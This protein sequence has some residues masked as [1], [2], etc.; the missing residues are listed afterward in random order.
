VNSDSKGFDIII[1]VFNEGENIIEL[2]KYL[3]NSSKNILRIYICYDFEQ[4]TSVHAIK[5]SEYAN[6]QNII[7]LKN[8]FAG[9]CE[10]VKTGFSQSQADAVI[11]YPADDFYN[12]LLLDKMYSFFIDGNDVI[13]PSRFIK[14]GIIKNCPFLKYFLVK[15]VS[16]IL[17]YITKLKIKDPTN[18]FRMFSRKTLNNIQIKSREGFA[19]SIEL[20]I[21]AKKQKLKIIELPSVWIERKD[22]KSSFKIFKWSPAYLKWFFLAFFI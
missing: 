7:L 22:R 18:G 21:K 1:P 4:D 20:L 19:Y 9:P 17:Y 5:N 3:N 12:G 15:T 11:V 2:I 6:N 10:A 14:G 13:C 16:F 8:F